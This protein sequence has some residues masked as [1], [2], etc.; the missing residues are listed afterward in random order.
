MLVFASLQMGLAQTPGPPLTL[1]QAEAIALKNHP[2]LLAAQ[3]TYLRSGQVAGQTRSAYFPT[4]NGEITGAQAN[5]SARLGAGAFNDPR[6]RSPC[7]FAGIA[8]VW[9]GQAACRR[10]K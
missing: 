10:W 3:A 8:K 4:L 1:Q 9:P 5:E 7:V 6:L 2:Q